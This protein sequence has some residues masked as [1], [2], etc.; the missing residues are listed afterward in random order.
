MNLKFNITDIFL[1]LKLTLVHLV[2]ARTMKRLQNWNWHQ[3]RCVRRMNNE[4]NAIISETSRQK[5][6]NETTD[7]HTDIRTGTGVLN[8]ISFDLRII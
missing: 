3:S 1:I 4:T 5:S 2:V 7:V 8:S 6:K